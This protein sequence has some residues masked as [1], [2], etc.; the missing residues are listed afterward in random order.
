MSESNLLRYSNKL[1]HAGVTLCVRGTTA[2]THD[3]AQRTPPFVVGPG[4]RRDDVWMEQ[5]RNVSTRIA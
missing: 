2:G 4:L 3:K 1:R 5:C